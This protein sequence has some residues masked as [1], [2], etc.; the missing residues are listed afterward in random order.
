MW[1]S[2]WRRLRWS[3]APGLCAESCWTGTSDDEG[4][5]PR[6]VGRSVVDC[7][8]GTVAGLRFRSNSPQR[9]TRTGSKG[10]S[11]SLTRTLATLARTSWPAT[12]WPKMVCLPFR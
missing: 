9:E 12:T 7:F 6:I 10:T 8:V 11:S 5:R 3:V 2:D 1:L 4:L